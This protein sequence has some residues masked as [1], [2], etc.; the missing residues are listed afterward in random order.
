ML[1]DRRDDF[2]DNDDVDLTGMI[3]QYNED[4]ELRRKINEMKKQKENAAQ[5]DFDPSDSA[6]VGNSFQSQ[7]DASRIPN[8]K[9]DQDV[10]KTR[11]GFNDESDKTLVIMDRK[12]KVDIKPEDMYDDYS[13][14]EPKKATAFRSQ[15]R[16]ET[17]EY[18]DLRHVVKGK[19]NKKND[20]FE[21]DEKTKRINKIIMI[22]II[23]V[24][25]IVLIVG[26]GFGVKYM[27]FNNDT[28]DSET[29]KDKDEKETT[30]NK[31]PTTNNNTNKNEKDNIEDNSAKIS[32]LNAQL[33]TYQTQLD[34]VNKK[35]VD[36]Q[37]QVNLFQGKLDAIPVLKQNLDTAA[38][39][40]IV[41]QKEYDDAKAKKAV[42]CSDKTSEACTLAT[43]TE[44]ETFTA[45]NSAITSRALSQGAYDKEYNQTADYDGKL[46][47]AQDTFNAL[48]KQRVDLETKVASTTTELAKYN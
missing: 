23:S 42:A 10:E 29:D 18:E 46:K 22:S 43:Q 36:A 21:E 11:V 35:L 37:S 14:V 39:A 15:S 19:K 5:P 8:I 16:E 41:A 45:L 12:S 44:T 17:E 3:H 13:Y 31:K 24:I 27:F 28:K 30:N 4:N 34:E 7:S 33:T 32:Q 48:D 26:V 6:L 20:D 25:S 2:D 9:A 40:V 38:Q 1:K 47:V